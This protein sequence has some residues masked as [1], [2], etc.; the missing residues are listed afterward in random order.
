M[1][2]CQYRLDEMTEKVIMALVLD[3]KQNE[4]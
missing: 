4:K 3:K 2:F 1:V